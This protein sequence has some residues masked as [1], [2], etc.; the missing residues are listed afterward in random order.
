VLVRH[1]RAQKCRAEELWREPCWVRDTL[2]TPARVCW[3]ALSVLFVAL[4]WRAALEHE[5]VVDELVRAAGGKEAL[6]GRLLAQLSG[7]DLPRLPSPT[8]VATEKATKWRMKSQTQVHID[9]IRYQFHHSPNDWW[10]TCIT[11]AGRHSSGGNG[12]IGKVSKSRW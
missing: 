4:Q 3:S 8:P 7:L 1:Y 11:T 12:V 5:G 2:L 10:W 6:E 9:Y